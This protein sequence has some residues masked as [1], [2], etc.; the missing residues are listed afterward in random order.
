[1]VLFSNTAIPR[2]RKFSR[3]ISSGPANLTGSSQCFLA[4]HTTPLESMGPPSTRNYAIFGSTTFQL[5][6]IRHSCTCRWSSGAKI[7]LLLPRKGECPIESRLS[8]GKCDVL[9]LPC[10]R[11][12]YSI[13]SRGSGKL[14]SEM[15]SGVFFRISVHCVSCLMGLGVKLMILWLS[16]LLI[17][18]LLLLPCPSF[19]PP[20]RLPVTCWMF[21]ASGTCRPSLSFCLIRT[22]W[23]RCGIR[24]LCG[25]GLMSSVVG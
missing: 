12:R 24:R 17:P 13:L 18:H 20:N 5:C 14:S 19:P 15:S 4:A 23:P 10:V 3:I 8:V 25:S 2:S 1:M 22:V 6:H 7:Y 11:P 16:S 21:L 9:V